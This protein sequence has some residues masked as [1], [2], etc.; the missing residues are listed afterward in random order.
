MPT[1]GIYEKYREEYS[2]NMQESR[3]VN[4]RMLKETMSKKISHVKQGE[5]KKKETSP[6]PIAVPI[7]REIPIGGYGNGYHRKEDI[8]LYAK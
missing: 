3:S 5:K 2:R 8:R 6:K 4:E 7:S 1:L